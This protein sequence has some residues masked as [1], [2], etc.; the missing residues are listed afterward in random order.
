MFN[1]FPSR[2]IFFAR[3]LFMMIRNNRMLFELLSINADVERINKLSIHYPLI[4]K[5]IGIILVNI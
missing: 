4:D 2:C 3:I 1:S 5:P